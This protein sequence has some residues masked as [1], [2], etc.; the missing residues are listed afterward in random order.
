MSVD[1]CDICLEGY[2]DDG[3]TCRKDVEIY[4]KKSY[5]RGV[6]EQLICQD[7][8]DQNGGFVILIYYIGGF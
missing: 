6:G 7:N 8:E 4:F 5:G 1:C 3:C 2:K